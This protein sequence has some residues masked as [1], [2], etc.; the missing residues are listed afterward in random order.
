MDKD[1]EVIAEDNHSP[2]NMSAKKKKSKIYKVTITRSYE[3]FVIA[4][5]KSHA[6]LQAKS[7]TLDSD[8]F[9]KEEVSA[10]SEVKNISDINS[11]INQEDYILHGYG[12]FQDLTIS[13][14]FDP[15]CHWF[16]IER[17]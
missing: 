10:P 17:N 5:S 3:E 16:Y 6:I 15:E 9:E 2:N 7:I 12:N 11:S 1:L 8:C 13:D 4:D 14:F